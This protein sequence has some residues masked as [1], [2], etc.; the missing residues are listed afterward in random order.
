LAPAARLV[1][2]LPER[3]LHPAIACLGSMLSHPAEFVTVA[4]DWRVAGA[5]LFS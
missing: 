1:V 4:G 3:D 5:E 2:V